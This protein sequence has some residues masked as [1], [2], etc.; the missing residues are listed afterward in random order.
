[1]T[2]NHM[3][4]PHYRTEITQHCIDMLAHGSKQE[5][6]GK[7]KASSESSSGGSCS[8]GIKPLQRRDR[9]CG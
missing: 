8:D 2:D 9:A 6:Y 7:R 1:M 5:A 3:A 4:T